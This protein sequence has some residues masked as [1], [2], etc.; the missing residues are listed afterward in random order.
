[1]NSPED[2]LVGPK[3]VE[4]RRFMNK[5]EMVTFVGFLISYVEKMHGTKSLKK[6]LHI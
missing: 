6:R 5:I 1:V 3:H 4:I 2:G